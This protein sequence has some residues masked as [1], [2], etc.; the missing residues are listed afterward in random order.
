MILQSSPSV[1]WETGKGVLRGQIIPFSAYEIR[2][3]KEQEELE[4]KIKHLKIINARNPSEETQN[5]FRKY[6]L[7]LNQIIHKKTQFLIHRL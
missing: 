3:E 5:E 2:K 7:Q 6:K 4:H 1:L